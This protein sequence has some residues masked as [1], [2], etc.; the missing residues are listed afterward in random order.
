MPIAMSYTLAEKQQMKSALVWTLVASV[1]YGGVAWGFTKV[2]DGGKQEFFWTLGILIAL[3]LAYLT[4]EFVIGIVVWRVY[5]RRV[6][7]NN[8]V[9]IMREG[10]LP[11]RVYCTD[12]TSSYLTRI[13]NAPNAYTCEYKAGQVTPE[14]KK[15]AAEL[16]TILSTVRGEHGI[17]AEARTRDAMKRALEIHSPGEASPQYVGLLVLTWLSSDITEAEIQK[18][19]NSSPELA[20]RILAERPFETL[21]DLYELLRSFGLDRMQAVH[22]LNGASGASEVWSRRR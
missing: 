15:V 10:K 19:P 21:T 5:G 22:F 7:V 8:F 11:K 13:I 4:M 2:I 9:A 12:D 16:A 20:K 1:F 14:I 18:L 17:V 3:R 6:A